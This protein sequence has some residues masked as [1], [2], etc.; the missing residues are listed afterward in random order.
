[1]YSMNAKT[2]DCL[3]KENFIDFHIYGFSCLDGK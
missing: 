1:M 2:E 3:P